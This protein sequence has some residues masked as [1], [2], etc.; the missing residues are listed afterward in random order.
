MFAK[1][2]FHSTVASFR[3][4]I[5]QVQVSFNHVFLRHFRN[6]IRVLR[7]SNRVP[8]IR[9]NYHRVPRIREIGS[10]QIHTRYLTFSIK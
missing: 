10:L 2:H 1:Y 3:F 5:Q 9:E 6:T 8:R 7:I 4:I